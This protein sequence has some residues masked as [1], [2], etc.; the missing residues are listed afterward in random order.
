MDE[1]K[2]TEGRTRGER[3]KKDW[4]KANRKRHMNPEWYAAN[5]AYSKGK[6]HCSCPMCAAKTRGNVTKKTG[7]AENWTISD[8][9]RLD[10]IQFQFLED[11]E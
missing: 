10:S 4:A 1:I 9:R 7:V 2:K 3:R 8:K 6:I 11:D 5:H